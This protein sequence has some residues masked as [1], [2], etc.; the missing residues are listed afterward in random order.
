MKLK[1]RK[2]KKVIWLFCVL[3]ITNFTY[4][5]DYCSGEIT[6]YEL[7]N[8]L[9][10]VEKVKTLDIAMQKLTVISPEIGKLKNLKCLDL[11]FNRMG[12][13]PDEFKNLRNLEYLNLSGTRFMAKLPVVLKELPNL[14]VLNI[15]DHPEWKTATWEEAK[16]MLPNVKI[17][18]E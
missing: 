12:T 7:E 5:Q 17:I 9:K 6:Y 10:E 1:I 18:T 8:A 15:A 3:L 2:M 14:K 4:A 16:K 11:S 13:L